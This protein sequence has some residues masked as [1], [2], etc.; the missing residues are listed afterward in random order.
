MRDILFK[1]LTSIDKRKRLFSIC[2][3]IEKD[4]ILTKLERKSIYIIKEKEQIKEL[5]NPPR[6]SIFKVCNTQ[7][8]E[9][10]LSWKIVGNFYVATEEKVFY[11]IFIHSFKIEAAVSPVQNK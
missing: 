1:E 7:R 9:E 4:G 3:A 5:K 10:R 11:I 2:E 6:I 8:Q